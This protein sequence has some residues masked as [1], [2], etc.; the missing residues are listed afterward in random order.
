[1]VYAERLRMLFHRPSKSFQEITNRPSFFRSSILIIIGTVIYCTIAEFGLFNDIN[2]H[3]IAAYALMFTIL[4]FLP[5][6]LSMAFFKVIGKKFNA[7][8]YMEASALSLFSVTTVVFIFLLAFMI[9][10]NLFAEPRRAVYFA[11]VYYS[12]LLPFMVVGAIA[13]IMMIHRALA[14]GKLVVNARI[15]QTV[16][17]WLVAGAIS[18]Y[19]AY[20]LF[21]GWL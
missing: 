10:S 3:F 11:V 8:S 21:R 7:E 16:I 2:G 4:W 19:I 14:I 20:L 15:Y 18:M 1:M 17:V 13:A 12:Q 9:Y 5:T 6:L